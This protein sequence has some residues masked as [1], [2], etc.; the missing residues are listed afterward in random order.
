MHKKKQLENVT[1][2]SIIILSILVEVHKFGTLKPRTHTITHVPNA[3][4]PPRLK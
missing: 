2:T 4:K 1:I 3:Q